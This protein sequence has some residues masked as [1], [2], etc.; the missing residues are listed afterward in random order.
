[1]NKGIK[2]LRNI[3]FVFVT[4]TLVTQLYPNALIFI[5]NIA[6][7][8]DDQMSN[9]L[10]TL[11]ISI[12]FA[13]ALYSLVEQ[14]VTERKCLYEFEIERDNLSFEEYRRFPTEL[15]NAYSYYYRRSNE[16]IEKPY[17]GIEVELQ[18]KALCSVGIPL[19]MEVSTGLFGESIGISNLRIIVKKNGKIEAK[20]SK[21]SQNLIIDMPIKDEKKF[22]IRIQLLCNHQLEKILLDSCIYLNFELTFKDDR[23]RKYRKYIFLKIQN[24]MGESKILSISSKNNWFSYIGKLIKQ[25]YQLNKKE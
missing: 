1:M 17:Y 25:F 20:K 8:T 6:K 11:D 24:A 19:R 18:E 10:A 15:K 7:L 21:L 13:I 12:S 4:I 5:T 23:G 3:L 22:L 9:I 16:D 14:K 2:I